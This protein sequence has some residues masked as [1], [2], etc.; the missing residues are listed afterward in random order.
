MHR[1]VSPNVSSVA[2]LLN[3]YPYVEE[4]AQHFI[5]TGVL[6]HH[7]DNNDPCLT[8]FTAQ[9]IQE[10][11]HQVDQVASY[12]LFPNEKLL[13]FSQLG[14]HILVLF[15]LLKFKMLL[16]LVLLPVLRLGLLKLNEKRIF[17]TLQNAELL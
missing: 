3:L 7:F 4:L 8:D 1:S 15:D 17:L 14:H 5:L 16:S 9:R 13:R 11:S 2:N 6:G 10:V 12:F